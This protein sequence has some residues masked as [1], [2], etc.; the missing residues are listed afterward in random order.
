MNRTLVFLLG[1]LAACVLAAPVAAATGTPTREYVVLYKA[2]V[3]LEDAK[4]AVKALDG[5]VVAS[6]KELRIMLVRADAAEFARAVRKS[7]K[8]VGAAENEAIGTLDPALRQKGDRV[9]QDGRAEAAGT[10]GVT[11]RDPD[12]DL[13][14]PL[15][16]WQW[17]MRMIDATAEG[18]YATQLG[19]KNVIVAVIDTGIDGSHPDI[20]PNFNRALSRN[21]TTDI[22]LIDGPCNKDPDM[23]CSDPAD[24]DEDGHG[25]HVAGTIASPINGLGMAGVAPNVTLVN[26]RAGQDSGFFFLWETVNALAY[27]GD[28]G[29]DVANMSFYTDP[30]Q[31]NCPTSH[32]ATNPVTGQPSDT[33]DQQAEQETILAVVQGAVDYAVGHGVTLV[34]AAGNFHSNLDGTTTDDTSPDFPPGTEQV[35]VVTD[36]C[37][38]MP[39][40]AD[41]VISV[42]S[43][44]PTTMKADYSNYGAGQETGGTGDDPAGEIDL[45]AP[46]GYFRDGLGTPLFRTPE[47]QILGPYPYEV[48]RAVHEISGSGKPTTPFVVR[49]C[50]AEKANSQANP[51]PQPTSITECSYYQLIQ[52]TSMASPHAAG[53]AALIVSQYGTTDLVHGGLTMD[54][55]AVR[56][57]L[58]ETATDTA[59]PTPPLVDYTLVGRPASWNALCEGTAA[60]NGFYGDGIVNALAAVGG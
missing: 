42:S 13:V 27:A 3:S 32:P 38:D 30:W 52:G 8:L 37:R 51:T 54:P 26:D 28:I 57:I 36:W 41:G 2:G 7:G 21:W 1:V 29:A 50:T 31:Y 33:A 23:S 44:G 39:T 18:S 35:R 20:A 6:R 19:S 58:R 45:A 55:A 5:K 56:E 49:D 9:E 11:V 15:A 59:C 16:D 34:A 47:T 22:P 25:T 40:E 4:S 10:G 17:D 43:V 60:Y 24:V 12:G 46:G 53:V 48:A 14:E